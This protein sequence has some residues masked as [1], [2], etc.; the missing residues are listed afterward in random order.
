LY[1]WSNGSLGCSHSLLVT[2]LPVNAS[3]GQE[4]VISKVTLA[5]LLPAQNLHCKWGKDA[6]AHLAS[7]P[8]TCKS[9]LVAALPVLESVAFSLGDTSRQG[10]V[11]LATHPKVLSASTRIRSCK[12]C[13][14]QSHGI[15]H[16]LTPHL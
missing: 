12:L 16:H 14:V 5:S 9:V 8:I 3:T 2:S 11:E 15:L 6:S 7:Q 1:G 4:L 13:I 10:E